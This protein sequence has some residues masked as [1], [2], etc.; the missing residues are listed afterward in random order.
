[1]TQQ[2]LETA[3]AL[4]APVGTPLM[5]RWRADQVRRAQAAADAMGNGV[6]RSDVIRMAFDQGITA[7]EALTPSADRP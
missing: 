2:D 3:V 4:A 7:V 1:M 5:T 6:T